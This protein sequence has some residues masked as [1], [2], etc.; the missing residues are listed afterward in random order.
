MVA[1]VI[2][3]L[4]DNVEYHWQRQ[5]KK[6]IGDFHGLGLSVHKEMKFY[7]PFDTY[8]HTPLLTQINTMKH[9]ISQHRA[10][11][12]VLPTLGTCSHTFVLGMT[13]I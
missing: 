3:S 6:D 5:E 7:T 9:Y 13:H 4:Y 8:K 10:F 2:A 1:E 12:V 11:G